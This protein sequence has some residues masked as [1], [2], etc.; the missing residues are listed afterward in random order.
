MRLCDF[1]YHLP[2][3][4]IAQEPAPERD[5]SRL[6]VLPETGAPVHRRFSDLVEMLDEK[7]LL[8]FN[9]TRV[10]PARLR[11]R[12][13]S[14]GAC[15]VLLDR[16]LDEERRQDGRFVS[17]WQ[18]LL[19]AA[20]PPRPGA[21]IGLPGGGRLRVVG[22]G[23]GPLWQVT[24]ALGRPWLEFLGECGEVPLPPY[25]QRKDGDLRTADDRAR[26]QTIFAREAGAVAAPTAG[27]HF[28]PRLLEAL[29]ARGVSF[30][31]VTLHVGPG[32]F[33]PIRSEE[34]EAHRVLSERYQIPAA[35]AGAVRA[36][37]ARGGRVVA[38]GTT[39][40]RALESAGRSGEPAAGEGITDLF[41]RPGYRFAVVDALVTNFHLPKSSLLLLVC[42]F[43]GRERILGAYAEA[44]RE[45]YRFY[46]Y[47]DA[48]FIARRAES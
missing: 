10:I 6:M 48:M 16:P 42:A 21:E 45:G 4:R 47:G 44:V 19:Q 39:V 13:E 1:D 5:G 31:R 33:L 15:E 18:C 27:L 38:V 22:R 26:Y 7:D 24:L 37:R 2:P 34:V 40:V 23:E 30:A 25:I 9:D 14:G 11:G 46:S 8:V 41:I 17:N 43:A 20:R 32:T 12:K 3:E 36:C 29:K 35:T 28:S